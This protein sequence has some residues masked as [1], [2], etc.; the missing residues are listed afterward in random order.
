MLVKPHLSTGALSSLF[1]KSNEQEQLQI[2]GFYDIQEHR[3]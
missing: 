3:D 1:F 2:K